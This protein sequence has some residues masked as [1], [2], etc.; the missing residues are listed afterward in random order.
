MT[1]LKTDDKAQIPPAPVIPSPPVTPAPAKSG[2]PTPEQIWG[3]PAGGLLAR[4]KT[5]I[6]G[7]TTAEFRSRLKT[8]GENKASD[9]KT[10][11]L[12]RASSSSVLRTR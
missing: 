10:V 12:W 6:E 7:L 8:Y 2:E 5:K 4:L 9:V 1:L 3:E 11:P